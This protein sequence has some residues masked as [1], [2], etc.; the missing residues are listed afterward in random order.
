MASTT[1][2]VVDNLNIV[3]TIYNF[4]R[5]VNGN[6]GLVSVS[7][8]IGINFVTEIIRK[9][10]EIIHHVT[11]GN[12]TFKSPVMKTRSLITKVA[13]DYA[14]EHHITTADFG[15]DKVSID[16]EKA[17]GAVMMLMYL[18]CGK[19]DYFTACQTNDKLSERTFFEH[20]DDMIQLFG[21]FYISFLEKFNDFCDFGIFPALFE[22]LVYYILC[23]DLG[24]SPTLWAEYVSMHPESKDVIDHDKRL[25]LMFVDPK[26]VNTHLRGF[27]QLHSV[28]Q[29][30]I[31]GSS[32]TRFLLAQMQQGEC[33]IGPIAEVMTLRK[34][35]GQ[36]I[37]LLLHSLFDVYGAA[38]HVN[39]NGSVTGTNR[40]VILY[41]VLINTL[42]VI[43]DIPNDDLT[44][45]EFAKMAYNDYLRNVC[46]LYGINIIDN[47]HF[48]NITPMIR[49]MLMYRLPFDKCH[50]F[51]TVWDNCL[52][53]DPDVMT[54]FTTYYS[55]D[56][57][58]PFIYY[59]PD[60]FMG[61]GMSNM[62]MV[63]KM[64]V[65]MIENTNIPLNVQGVI[66]GATLN[67]LWKSPTK[68]TPDDVV[69]T[70]VGTT[71]S[72]GITYCDYKVDLK[73]KDQPKS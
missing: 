51:K 37:F 35:R 59:G 33:G 29:D 27:S 18:M 61:A 17:F 9:Y 38:F 6:H 16:F 23:N 11:P 30:L 19:Y 48:K 39:N 32:S 49:T 10:P 24:K 72:N 44:N 56:S 45:T 57:M 73:P 46:N 36:F 71:D 15:D 21:N 54:R 60:W 3:N 25:H 67:P 55:I 66:H 41:Q 68:P 50:E 22:G 13:I 2:Q 14:T 47:N 69:L 26:F 7:D 62:L 52:Q 34:N 4:I 53:T 12:P 64:I 20:R 43:S 40:S 31:I 28:V 42:V 5:K 58:R 1:H 65:H 70:F 8:E 63:I